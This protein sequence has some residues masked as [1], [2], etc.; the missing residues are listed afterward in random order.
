MTPENLL[1]PRSLEFVRTPHESPRSDDEPSCRQI[2]DRHL[3][4]G[5]LDRTELGDR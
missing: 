2:V 1:A 5:R 3:R 4:V